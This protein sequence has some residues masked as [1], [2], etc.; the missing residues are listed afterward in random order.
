MPLYRQRPTPRNRQ[1]KTESA[2]GEGVGVRACFFSLYDPCPLFNRLRRGIYGEVKRQHQTLLSTSLLPMGL[3]ALSA[4]RLHHPGQVRVIGGLIDL[5]RFDAQW[6]EGR[7]T[8]ETWLAE[9]K[10]VTADKTLRLSASRLRDQ[11]DRDA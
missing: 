9:M 5:R 6:L 1:H 3:L 4:R 8:L 2:V 7:L 11:D 10:L